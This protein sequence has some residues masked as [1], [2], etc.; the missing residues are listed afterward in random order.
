M[1]D[2]PTVLQIVVHRGS[3]L[4]NPNFISK[5]DPY[6]EMQVGDLVLKTRTEKNGGKNP[7]WEQTLSFPYNNE[8]F[9]SFR[10]YDKDLV[11]ADDFIG[12]CEFPI[13]HI[14]T[15]TTR[16]YSGAVPLTRN[17]GKKAGYIDV[18]LRFFGS[19]VDSLSRHSE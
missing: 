9:M 8:A 5:S 13:Q 1:K 10:V 7:R 6:V 17:K 3:D 15:S 4:Y 12:S 11:S 2:L 14:A 19:L 16:E 18:T